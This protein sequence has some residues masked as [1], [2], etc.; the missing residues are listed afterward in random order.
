MMFP[1]LFHLKPCL[2]YLQSINFNRLLITKKFTDTTILY[3]I[4]DFLTS[5]S[6]TYLAQLSWCTVSSIGVRNQCKMQA[7]L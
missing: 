6:F 5:F 2:I 3:L 7:W 4:S 1:H